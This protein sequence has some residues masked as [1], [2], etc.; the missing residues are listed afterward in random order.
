MNRL[1]SLLPVALVALVCGFLGAW[2]F[3]LTGLGNA[4]TKDWL[5][6]N[7]EI[8]PQ[9]AE[10]YRAKEMNQRLAGIESELTR[11]FPAAVLGNPQG[12]VTLVQFSDY[13]CGYCRQSVP[14]V[15]ALIAANPDLRVVVREWP[16]FQGSDVTAGLALAAAQQGKYAA[17]HDALYAGGPPSDA[18]I[19]AAA[20]KV[21]LDMAAAQQFMQNPAVR[22]E[23]QN[24]QRLAMQL[25]FEGTPGWVVGTQVLSGAVGREQLAAAIEEARKAT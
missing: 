23:F 9:V 24:N 15:K 16:I 4:S 6:E 22:S 21:G 18:S 25:G 11:P 5:L 7:P 19:K 3:A 8:L 1:V 13:A 20:Q 10:A 2:A 12:K 17:F 14:D